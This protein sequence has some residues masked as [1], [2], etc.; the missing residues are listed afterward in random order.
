MLF[1]FW[2]GNI[3]PS[4]ELRTLTLFHDDL[5]FKKCVQLTSCL[6]LIPLNSIDSAWRYITS[7]WPLNISLVDELKSYIQNTWLSN[8]DESLFSPRTWNKY[9]IIRGRTNNTAEGFHSKLNKKVNKYTVSFWE[10]GSILKSIQIHCDIEF[11]RILGGGRPKSRKKVYVD[12]ETH[13][14]RIW[15]QFENDEISLI[16]LINELR[17]IIKLEI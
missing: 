2:T 7:M 17:H 1:S 6:A 11:R 13:I 4:S 9:G 3:P 16:E 14:S 8:N 12:Q 15:M 5:T 10:I